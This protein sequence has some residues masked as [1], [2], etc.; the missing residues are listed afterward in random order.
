MCVRE[1][2]RKRKKERFHGSGSIKKKWG[3]VWLEH[4]SFS[5]DICAL[6]LTKFSLGV[7]RRRMFL[8]LNL[9]VSLKLKMCQMMQFSTWNSFHRHVDKAHCILGSTNPLY[10]QKNRS[11]ELSYEAVPYHMHFS[12]RSLHLFPL[13]AWKS[14]HF[15]CSSF[16]KYLFFGQLFLFLIGIFL[17]LPFFLKRTE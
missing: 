6:I 3:V 12:C 10:P 5:K 4:S 9:D 14:L 17:F 1:K 15:T 11:S 7:D 16:V 8:W 13:S 2:K